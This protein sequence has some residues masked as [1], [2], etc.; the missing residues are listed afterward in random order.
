M[1][2]K[3]RFHVKINYKL[4]SGI[5]FCKATDTLA[6]S[7]PFDSFAENVASF[8]FYVAKSNNTKV[9]VSVAMSGNNNTGGWSSYRWD[10]N[11]QRTYDF[12]NNPKD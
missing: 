7:A 2:M 4:M 5:D 10:F 12:K 6:K 8:L 1:M 3:K 11:Q 9:W